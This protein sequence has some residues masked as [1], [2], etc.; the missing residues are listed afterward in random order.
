MGVR[1]V[2]SFVFSFVHGLI[3]GTDTDSGTGSSF[4]TASTAVKRLRQGLD[5]RNTN[6]FTG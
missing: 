5:L 4:N 1:S 2:L 6:D 3:F